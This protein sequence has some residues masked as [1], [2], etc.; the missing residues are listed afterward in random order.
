[1]E[2]ASYYFIGLLTQ[3]PTFLTTLVC[4]VVALV[5]WKRHPRTSLIVILSLVLLLCEGLAIGAVE[6]FV[7]IW[8]EN[9]GKTESF[10]SFYMI[11]GVIYNFA[12]ALTLALLLWAIFGRR[13]QAGAQAL[14]A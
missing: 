14:P 13:T 3:L 2:N 12:E 5:G 10:G 8:L 11:T 7:P 1:M 6:Y 4:V 9:N